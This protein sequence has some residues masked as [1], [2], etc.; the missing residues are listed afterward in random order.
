MGGMNPRPRVI[1]VLF[2][3]KSSRGFTLIE[4]LA[5][6]AIVGVLAALILATL[7][8]MRA[9]ARMAKCAS[10][11]RS[12][13]GAFNQFAADYRGYYPAVTY[14]TSQL[15]GRVNPNKAHW[16][17]ELK[18]YIGVD[19]KTIG[20]IEGNPFAICPDGLTGMNGKFNYYF[21]TPRATVGQPSRTI[22]AGDSQSHVLSVWIGDPTGDLLTSDP[23]RHRGRANYLF[24]D[25]HLE[26]LGITDAAKAFNRDPYAQ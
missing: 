7:G 8:P 21:Q 18:P 12:I 3:A 24:A 26:G 6:V 25:G 11:L 23:D 15:N 9:N 2:S 19:I 16:W 22:L 10:N 14:N 20:G 17:L 5:V 1:P 4:L 13:G